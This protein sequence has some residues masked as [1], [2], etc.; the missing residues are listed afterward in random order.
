MHTRLQA[1]VHRHKKRPRTYI[2]TRLHAEVHRHK[3]RPRHLFT[4]GYMQKYIDIKRD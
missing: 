3:K 1:E 4:L 2:H